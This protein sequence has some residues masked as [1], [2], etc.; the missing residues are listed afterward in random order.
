VLDPAASR[1]HDPECRLR[2]LGEDLDAAQQDVLEARG[3]AA[4][5]AAFLMGGE[6]LLR[7][8]R[9]ALRAA[10]DPLDELVVWPGPEDAGQQVGDI[11]TVEAA[12]L[13]PLGPSAAVQSGQ[14]RPQGMPPVQLVGAVGQ[15]Q[16]QRC[17]Q[18]A[19]EEGEQVQG[20]AI[21]PVQVLDHQH[22][23]GPTGE[24]LQQGEE[25][26]EH[27]G[28]RRPADGQPGRRRL[29]AL[30][31][32]GQQ[33]G[34]QRPSGSGQ[35]VQRRGLQPPGQTAERLDYGCVGQ[36]PLAELDAAAEQHLP[37]APADLTGE[38]GDQAGLPDA[39]LTAD[40]QR[41]RIAAAGVRER[42]LKTAQLR[43]ATD[44]AR[45]RDGPGH[46]EKYA[47]RLLGPERTAGR[48]PVLVQADPRAGSGLTPHPTHP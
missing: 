13:E 48:L 29:L 9:V 2:V 40:A 25:R 23:R 3:Q 47:L 20:R 21:G 19:D 5:A 45:G 17:P 41:H 34:Q 32:L 44:E 26:L 15:H 38:P 43:C 16:E 27:P 31:E 8:E 18:V 24:T 7:E 22:G 42:R 6:Q 39:G 12:H 28:L 11:D 37:A 46:G 33:A 14:E 10:V 36:R 30:P 4:P 35:L 1:G